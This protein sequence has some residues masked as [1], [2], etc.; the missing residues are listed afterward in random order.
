VNAC[1][2]R[3]F[4]DVIS[5]IHVNS[6]TGVVGADIFDISRNVGAPNDSG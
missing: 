6:L 5:M 1:H 2:A 4:A 3:I